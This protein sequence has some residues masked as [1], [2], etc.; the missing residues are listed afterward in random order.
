MGGTIQICKRT[1]QRERERERERERTEEGK[2][3]E[4]IGRFPRKEEGEMERDA[5]EL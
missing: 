2:R 5:M 1:T 3:R 4:G